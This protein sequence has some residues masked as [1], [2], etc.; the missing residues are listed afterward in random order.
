MLQKY[1][2]A[3]GYLF[4]NGLAHVTKLHPNAEIPFKEHQFD[5]TWELTVIGRDEN[6]VEDVFQDVN[7]FT[8]GISL[9]CPKG[10]HFEIIEHP[11]LYKA[12]YSM[13]GGPRIINPE[14]ESEI[15]LPLMKFKETDDIELP[16]RAAVIILRQTE[17]MPIDSK[18]EA[19]NAKSGRGAAKEY[20]SKEYEDEEPKKLGKGTRGRRRNNMF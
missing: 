13:V 20:A 3:E 7:V 18:G 15:K 6:R 4:L 19:Q 1:L 2:S 10:Y 14:D 17:Y 8:T 16:F 12:G 9:K 11:Q 5:A